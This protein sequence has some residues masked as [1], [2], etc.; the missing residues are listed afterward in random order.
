[1]DEDN[2]STL[3]NIWND[4]GPFNMDLFSHRLILQKKIFLLQQLGLKSDYSFKIYLRG[5]YCSQL[6]TDGYKIKALEHI[7]N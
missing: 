3:C 7:G 2:F 6:A 5:P 4:I 1:M